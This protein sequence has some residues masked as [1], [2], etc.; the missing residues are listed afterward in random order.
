VIAGATR[1]EQI[2]QNANAAS[3]W[4]PSSEE[5]AEISGFFA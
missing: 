1:P 5:V 3:A 4:H 2:V